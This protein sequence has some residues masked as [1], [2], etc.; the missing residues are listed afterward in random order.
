[1]NRL[2]V[3]SFLFV[4][5]FPSVS[6]ALDITNITPRYGPFGMSART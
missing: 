3:A 5:L 6:P 2:L 1:M 4:G